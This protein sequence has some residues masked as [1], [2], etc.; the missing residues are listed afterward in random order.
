MPTTVLSHLA[1][2]LSTHPENLATEAL[3]YV[4]SS[5]PGAQ[6][7]LAKLVQQLGFFPSSKLSYKTQKS[8]EDGKR[9]DLIGS[10]P[11]GIAEVYIEAKFWAG[12]TDAQPVLYLKRLPDTGGMLLFVVPEQRI[13]TIWSE[14]LRRCNDDGMQYDEENDVGQDRY[15]RLG[16]KY[17]ALISWRRLLDHIAEALNTVGDILHVADVQQLL[18]LSES[19]DRQAFLPLHSEEL[20][21]SLGKRVIE[22]GEIANDLTNK[23]VHNGLASVKNLRPSGSNGYYGRYLR[24]NEHGSFLGFYAQYWRD[25]GES[26]LWLQIRG[27]SWEPVPEVKDILLRKGHKAYESNDGNINVP[28]Y[29]VTG[30]ERDALIDHCYSQLVSIAKLLPS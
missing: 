4:L 1:L 27:P 3:G 29:L 19:M 13:E 16:Q 28:I 11:K 25:H 30:V 17:L 12:L 5:S 22:F 2:K 7:A 18:G 14:L 9:P 8:N 23:L 21:G 20:T 24:L 15:I 10:T 6:S 26:P